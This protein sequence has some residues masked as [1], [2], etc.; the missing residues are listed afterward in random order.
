[1]KHNES[2]AT[3]KVCPSC[4][5]KGFTVIPEEWQYK[6]G[7]ILC[8]VLLRMFPNLRVISMDFK[9]HYNSRFS[10]EHFCSLFPEELLLEHGNIE[11]IE[12][13]GGD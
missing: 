12:I 3:E 2:L 6:N 9:Y 11:M 5:G 4:D 13:I 8:P 10:L 1:M 7:D